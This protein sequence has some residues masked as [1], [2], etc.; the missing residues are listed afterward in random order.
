MHLNIRKW[1]LIKTRKCS[2]T[3]LTL[4]PLKK[5]TDAWVSSAPPKKKKSPK[6]K[7]DE[8]NIHIK[9]YKNVVS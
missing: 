2:P 7:V 5:L 9:T 8:G 1:A 4:H 3:G 6:D